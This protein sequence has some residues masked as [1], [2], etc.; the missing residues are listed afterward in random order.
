MSTEFSIRD[1]LTPALR[2][3]LARI[4]DKRP[5]L[6]A[7][8]A[9]LAGVAT[10]AFRDEALRPSEWA[11]LA[12][13]TLRRKRGGG[14]L[15]DTGALYRSVIAQAPGRDSI[16]VGSDREYSLFHQWGTRK[17]PA[18]PFFPIDDKGFTQPGQQAVMEAVS[19]ALNAA[20]R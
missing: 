14:P 9:A 18:R 13:S 12:E 10:R 7:A 3:K 5:I 20:L 6:E 19:A 15:I 1:E 2:K 4:S 11:P 8:G 17:M 16:E